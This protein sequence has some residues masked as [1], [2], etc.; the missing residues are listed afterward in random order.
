MGNSRVGNSI[1]LSFTSEVREQKPPTACR[2]FWEASAPLNIIEFVV[3]LGQHKSSWT[4]QPF[5][6][7]RTLSCTYLAASHGINFTNC[8]KALNASNH[9]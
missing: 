2:N 4:C 5:A 6:I 9:L 3:L 7:N 1:V 8:I